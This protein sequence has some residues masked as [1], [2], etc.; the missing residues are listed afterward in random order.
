M[1]YLEENTNAVSLLSKNTQSNFIL[2]VY[3]LLSIQLI[4]TWVMSF[5][6]Y[7]NTTI[8]QFVL[9]NTSL[10]IINTIGS[11]I[12]LFLSFCYGNIYPYNYIILFGFTLCESYT[13]S[14]VCLFYQPM[15]ILFAWGVTAS[16]FVFLTLYVLIT[17]QNFDF[18]KAGLASCLWILIIGG[19][20]QIFWFPQQPLLNTLFAIFGAMVACGYIL[21]DTSVIIRK[22]SPD[23]FVYACMSLYLD[24]IMLFLRILELFGKEKD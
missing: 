7:M 3:S 24:I 8:S 23:D 21:Y 17:K 9:H 22:L 20:F 15:S 11:F 16:I 18:L 1:D 13:I 4:I 5:T 12:F 19:I 10:I 14:I 2:K 6:F